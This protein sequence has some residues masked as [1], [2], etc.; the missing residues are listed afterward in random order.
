MEAYTS[1][2]TATKVRRREG[3]RRHQSFAQPTL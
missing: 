3:R 2:F 1:K